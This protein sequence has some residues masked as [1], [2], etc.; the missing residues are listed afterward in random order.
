VFCSFSLLPC[1]RFIVEL[2]FFIG[3]I[4]LILAV[5][6]EDQTRCHKTELDLVKPTPSFHVQLPSLIVCLAADR[7]VQAN[8]SEMAAVTDETTTAGD[9]QLTL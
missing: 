5:R 3:S 1:Y 2:K 9:D 8:V 6:C 7:A 4:L